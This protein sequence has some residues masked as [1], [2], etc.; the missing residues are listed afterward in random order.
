MTITKDGRIV[1]NADAGELLR[2]AGGKFVHILWDAAAYKIALRPLA[3]TNRSAFKLT[4]KR[5]RR[6][7]V[8]SG[9]TF[10]R[11]IRWDLSKTVTV[12]VEWNEKERVLE[13]SLMAVGR[14]TRSQSE[15]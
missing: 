11:Y 5:G 3:K 15:K 4:T 9:A 7:M 8:I 6:S 14:F 10:L 13:A 12:P 2:R 1:L